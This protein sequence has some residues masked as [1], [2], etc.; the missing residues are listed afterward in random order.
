MEILSFKV[1]GKLAHFRKYYAN[2]TALSFSIPPRTTLIGI[3]AAV[4][5]WTKDSY[6]ER[7]S[8]ENIH[9][10]IRVLSPLKKSFQ[11]LN[12]LS[13]KSTGDI[14]KSLNSDFRGK[15]GR[16]QTPFEVVS[17]QNIAEGE[18]IY[19][20]FL[21]AEESGQTTFDEIKEQ[22]LNKEPIYNLSL[23]PANFQAAI[24]CKRLITSEAIKE[25]KSDDFIFIHSAVPSKFVE[26]LQF[27]KDDYEQYNFVE[28]DML[29]GDFVE[30]NN[31][32]VRKMNRLLFSI[33]N[34]PLR[35]RI[36]TS[37]L[38]INAGDEDMNIQ[39]MDA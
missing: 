1:K 17:A 7:L 28:E 13:I 5:G 36:N 12:F 38:Q 22:I 31:R 39:F 14:S 15:R 16:I 37:F 27:A 24:Y 34:L 20:V 32:E 35:I 21:S 10:G 2:N 4:M 19:Q 18:V 26:E 29:P 11:R 6:Y 3:V 9:F 33:T 25:E 30:N 23:G 8:S